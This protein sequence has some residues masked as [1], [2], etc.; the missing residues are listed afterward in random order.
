MDVK[1]ELNIRND[2]FSGSIF[3]TN[4]VLVDLDMLLDVWYAKV[5]ANGGSRYL[6][7]GYHEDY[8]EP[9][10]MRFDNHARIDL[11]LLSFQP[12]GR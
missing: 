10:S 5:V 9:G 11:P 7:L 4:T 6:N 1:N 2:G 3:P 8:N 12:C